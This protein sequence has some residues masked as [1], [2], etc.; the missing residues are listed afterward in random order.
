[1]PSFRYDFTEGI[2]SFP[3]FPQDVKLPR[4]DLRLQV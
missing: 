4:I 3:K 2:L 1:M